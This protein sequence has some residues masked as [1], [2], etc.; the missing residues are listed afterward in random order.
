MWLRNTIKTPAPQLDRTFLCPYL[1]FSYIKTGFYKEV[2]MR[3]RGSTHTAKRPATPGRC[4]SHLS[5][6]APHPHNGPRDPAERTLPGAG[7]GRLQAGS[8]SPEVPPAV[9]VMGIRTET[10]FTI[11]S[12]VALQPSL[13]LLVEEPWR[14][15]LRLNVFTVV[16]EDASSLSAGREP[17]RTSVA[18]RLDR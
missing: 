3:W 8:Y 13:V 1:Y 18:Q 2:E 6:P 11:R 7:L 17:V 9:K 14:M 15:K 10:T 4:V 5:D 12:S 16:T